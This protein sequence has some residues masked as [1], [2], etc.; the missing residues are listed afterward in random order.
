V[1]GDIGH[2][3]TAPGT[4]RV[5]SVA[6]PNFGVP[7]RRSSY[8]P[9]DGLAVFVKGLLLVAPGRTVTVRIHSSRPSRV[10]LL[11]GK[12]FEPRAQWHGAGWFRISDGSAALTFK[13]CPRSRSSHWTQFAGGFLVR[14]A[15][16]AIVEARAQ[17][18]SRWRRRPIAFGKGTC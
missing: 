15:Q 11:Y 4:I 12:S 9:H 7:R 14:G 10:A 6:W 13:A 5:G 8:G 16:C 18:S 2:W 17:G 1:Y 3:R